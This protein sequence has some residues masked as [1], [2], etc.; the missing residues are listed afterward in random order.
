MST[1]EN[2]TQAYAEA[3]LNLVPSFKAELQ[4]PLAE[5]AQA[6]ARFDSQE[7]LLMAIAT[8]GGVALLDA[9]DELK[10]DKV[11]VLE[12]VKWHPCALRDASPG[13]QADRE[14][15]LVAVT[16]DGAAL[17]Y[18]AASLQADKELVSVA[19]RT[20]GGALDDASEALKADKELVLVA[21]KTQGAAL[22]F[23]ADSMQADSDVVVNAVRQNGSAIEYADD[24]DDFRDAV[25]IELYPA[26]KAH[27]IVAKAKAKYAD[28]VAAIVQRWEDHKLQVAAASTVATNITESAGRKAEMAGMTAAWKAAKQEKD[29]TGAKEI[30]I[31]LD[32]AIAADAQA[33]AEAK[34][35]VTSPYETK[36][37]VERARD[38][39]IT[40]SMHRSCLKYLEDA[41]RRESD[42]LGEADKYDLAT[43]LDEAADAASEL[44]TWAEE[45]FPDQYSP[46][47]GEL[48]LESQVMGC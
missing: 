2:Q 39:L 23:A 7:E 24:E 18:A 1:E 48:A 32:A 4:E 27:G 43:S 37:D 22:S 35:G 25:L 8:K 3:P 19:C 11:C 38:A 46:D 6:E 42:R 17:R 28:D 20:C 44:A 29:W 45:W 30:R 36:S 47:W 16:Q 31:T 5:Q 34:A 10:D 21:V 26:G 12:A 41:Y 40:S 13:M 33:E 15:V 14:V 9:S